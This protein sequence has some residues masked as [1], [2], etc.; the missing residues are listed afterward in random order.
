MFLISLSPVSTAAF[1]LVDE[2][3]Q[4]MDASNER[5]VMTQLINILQGEPDAGAG[6]GASAAAAAAAGDDVPRSQLFII[7]P[8]LL[9]DMHHSPL[10]RTEVVFNGAKVGPGQGATGGVGAPA[11][12]ATRFFDFGTYAKKLELSKQAA[13]LKPPKAAKAA[14]AAVDVGADGPDDRSLL[15]KRAR[16]GSSPGARAASAAAH[17]EDD[18]DDDDP[19]AQRRLGKAARH[20]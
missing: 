6:A 18:D 4:G 9:L 14:A 16:D 11:R 7:S 8:K 20:A 12:L 5:A 10:I 15:G 19:P 1:R 3:N 17:G 2:I 13:P